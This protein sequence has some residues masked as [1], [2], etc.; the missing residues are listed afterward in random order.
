LFCCIFNSHNTASSHI[1]IVSDVSV[2]GRA[3]VAVHKLL[4]V[5]ADTNSV[6]TG[7]PFTVSGPVIFVTLNPYVS[8]FCPPL[9]LAAIVNVT[10]ELA[11]NSYVPK[12]SKETFPSASIFLSLVTLFQLLSIKYTFF[13]F[14]YLPYQIAVKSID[15]NLT[16]SSHAL[17]FI[18]HIS[19]QATA[20]GAWLTE[21][22][23]SET[24]KLPYVTPAS[25]SCSSGSCSPLQAATQ[26]S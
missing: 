26:A 9:I 15:V 24:V 17:N 14:V 6:S 12:K 16:S 20:I 5:T 10:V 7:N 22:L 25:G 11:F 23:P 3:K 4:I 2:V 1:V 19:T 8:P 21:A 18:D 13:R